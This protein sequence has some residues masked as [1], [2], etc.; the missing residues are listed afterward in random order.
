MGMKRSQLSTPQIPIVEAKESA[1]EPVTPTVTNPTPTQDVRFTALYRFLS[2]TK[3]PMLDVTNDLIKAADIYG[4]DYALL[5]AIAMQESNGC[6]I[7]PQDS[8]N[9]WG[10]GIYGTKI[11]RFSSYSEAI[12]QIAKTIKETYIKKGMTNPT[13]LEDYWTPSSRGSWSYA[14]NYFINKIHLHE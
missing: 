9:C 3:S 5:P 11:T 8:Y 10:F 1:Y 6:K 2:E 13:L 4:L 7:I 12:F 14:V